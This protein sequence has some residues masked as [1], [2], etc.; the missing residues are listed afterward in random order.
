MNQTYHTSDSTYSWPVV[1]LKNVHIWLMWISFR[2]SCLPWDYPETAFC[3]SSDKDTDRESSLL[4]L[5]LL[6]CCTFKTTS[7]RKE[8]G[9]SSHSY[10]SC[11]MPTIILNWRSLA[12]V[13]QGQEFSNSRG[14]EDRSLFI[15]L[16]QLGSCRVYLLSSFLNCFS[17]RS[18]LLTGAWSILFSKHYTVLLLESLCAEAFDGRKADYSDTSQ[19]QKIWW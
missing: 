6:Q 13:A 1:S 7:V 18:S 8:T 4:C 15:Q 9:N 5:L 14:Q 12:S 2:F 19:M 10:N 11:A 3:K 16:L 17:F